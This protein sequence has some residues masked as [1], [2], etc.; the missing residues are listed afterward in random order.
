M[1]S[2][3]NLKDL[4]ISFIFLKKLLGSILTGGMHIKPITSS[5][6][7]LQNKIKFFV[8]NWSIPD[9]WDSFPIFTWIKIL[10]FFLILDC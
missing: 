9:F 10:I 3:Q 2:S 7:S 1:L 5:P 6:S 4:L 8:A